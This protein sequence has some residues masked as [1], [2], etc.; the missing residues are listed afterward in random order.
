MNPRHGSG[1]IAA[2]LPAQ[3]CS[4]VKF[5]TEHLS[6]FVQAQP[7]T[8]HLVVVG[9]LNIIA[10]PDLDKSSGI[11]SGK[12]NQRFISLWPAHDLRDAFR[13]LHPT[14]KQYTFRVKA[15]QAKSRID[16]ALVSTSLLGNLLEASHAEVPRKLTDHWFAIRLALRIVSSQEHGPGLWRFQATRKDNK[17]VRKVIE[18]AVRAPMSDSRHP[19]EQVISRL[20]MGLRAH[21][22]EEQATVSQGG[23]VGGIPRKR[24]GE[25][26]GF[27]GLTAELQG[28]VPSPYLSAKVKT[29]KERTVINEVVFKGQRFKGSKEVLKAASAHFAEAFSE[30][31]GGAEL[32][33]PFTVD[34]VLPDEAVRR[35]KAPWTEPEVKSALAGLPR[36]K[37][38]VQDGLP[39]ELFTSHWDLLGGVFMDFVRG[40]ETT[41][42]LPESVTTA[43][44]VLLHKKG[45]KDQLSNY[46]PITLLNTVYKVLAK[47]MAN[48]FKKE[49]HQIISAEQ[50]GFIPGRSLA[51]AVAVVADAIEAADNDGED[52]YLLMVDFQKAYDTV[53]RPYLF[54]TLEKLGL[55]ADFIRWVEGL[56]HG[57]GTKI[58][59]NGWIGEKV[60][61]RRGVRQGCPLAP[62]LFLCVLEPLC[63][64]IRKKGCGVK[65]EEGEEVAYV[66]Y[67]DDTSLIL[68]GAEQ[69]HSAA[70]V[71]EWFGGVSGLHTN[72]E[73]SVVMPL[74][75]NRGKTALP[76][77]NFKWAADGK[78]ERLLGVWVMPDGDAAPSWEKAWERGKK[79][80]VKWENQHLL[81]AAR[82]TVINN[83]IM[84]I[85]LFQA[86]IYPPPEELWA[87]IK[88]TCDNY[89]S[90]GQATADKLFVLW[91]GELAR[92]PKKEGGLGLVDPKARLDSL[93]IRMVGKLL[94]EKNITKKWLAEKSSFTAARSGYPVRTQVSRQTLGEGESE[95]ESGSRGFLGLTLC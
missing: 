61:M 55:P 47:V 91:S 1:L 33:R 70:E 65:A 31:D 39:A 50:H 30:A 26:G 71:L 20:T 76:G 2:Y 90:K 9:D 94:T 48:R 80:L 62:Y 58:A 18:K 34:R 87:K 44:T 52:W 89:V 10:D 35:L 72:R 86:Q 37:S 68:R 27:A 8:A 21:E 74:G 81:T 77:V 84:P 66:G 23:A 4:R 95:V 11:G 92:L 64:E 41:G 51:D 24:Q 59:V 45:E 85:F 49:L 32:R 78:P 42:K 29:R 83:Y 69:L 40:F 63:S 16:R 13:A 56:H 67:A 43:V 28:E 46:R 93:A 88:K 22:K 12:E 57:S 25:T 73:K 53:S 15:T 5:H 82:V 75:R 79:E 3:A 17:G 19:L 36:G 6:P 7:S 38:P 14:E 60:D 54:E